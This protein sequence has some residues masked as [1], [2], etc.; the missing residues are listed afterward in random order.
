MGAKYIATLSRAGADNITKKTFV[1]EMKDIGVDLLIY[2]GSVVDIKD[3]RRLKELTGQHPIRGI[4][5]GA[6]V[7]QV[8]L[9]LTSMNK[10]C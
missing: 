10:L 7:L 4:V 2:H 3:V 5:Q 6:M 1:K 8:V 9:P